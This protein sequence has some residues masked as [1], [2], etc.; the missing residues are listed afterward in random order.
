[1]LYI[2]FLFLFFPSFSMHV[3][4]DEN[5]FHKEA[6]KT[7]F[8][9]YRIFS[10][11]F[12][13]KRLEFFF[14]HN[15]Y[16]F[17]LKR[18][19]FLKGLS[20][21]KEKHFLRYPFFKDLSIF[22][23]FQKVSLSG[24]LEKEENGSEE[25]YNYFLHLFESDFVPS[26]VSDSFSD[27][28]SSV[29]L[30]NNHQNNDV[31][32]VASSK[33]FPCLCG[34]CFNESEHNQ[35]EGNDSIHS[36]ESKDFPCLCGECFNESEHNELEGNRS[37]HSSDINYEKS[38]SDSSLLSYVYFHEPEIQNA[39]SLPSFFDFNFADFEDVDYYSSDFLNS[40]ER[41]FVGYWIN[42][43]EEDNELHL[44]PLFKTFSEEQEK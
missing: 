11:S 37:I 23:N 17:F 34:V 40:R 36:S 5:V 33:N 14:K 43:P 12:M 16:K 29:E 24:L 39:A 8:P 28:S 30:Q 44:P 31:D 2:L 19:L 21:F 15:N 20:S 6:K 26:S 22:I 18:P 10:S 4:Q 42:S 32:L 1:M 3:F 9:F 13:F 27:V 35:S 41:N 38:S 7:L 25:T